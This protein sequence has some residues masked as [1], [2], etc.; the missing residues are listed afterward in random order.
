MIFIIIGVI[1]VW[2]WLIV[3]IEGL[4][5]ERRCLKI[6][7]SAR[8]SSHSLVSVVIP[9]RNE[10]RKIAE[11]LQSIENQDYKNIQVI[12]VNDRS[13]DQTQQIMEQFAKKNSHWILR[14]VQDLPQGWLGKNN[15]LRVGAREA[16]GHYLLFTD[17]DVK[18]ESQAIR[19]AVELSET[20]NLDHLVLFPRLISNDLLMSAMQCIF[21]VFFL[22]I[23]KPSKIGRSANYYVGVGA[24][25]LV[26]TSFY[27]KIGGH[28]KLRLEIID[29]LMLG[30]V[31]VA[32]GGK[33]EALIGKNL[34]SVEWYSDWRE[35]IQ[36]FEKNGFAAFRYSLFSFFLRT[37]LTFFFNL[38]PYVSL[39][40]ARGLGLY[41]ILLSLVMMFAI[42]SQ[43]AKKMDYSPMVLFLA[44]LGSWLIW[45]AQLRSVI[46]TL[47]NGGVSWRDTK[48][49]LSDLRK[50][51]I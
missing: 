49:N 4:R 48:Y 22:T 37:L 32:A 43:A 1:L 34:L 10:A 41:L 51:M 29:D 15:A 21:S 20:L 13:T 47:Y 30:K 35:M 39:F 7:N 11:C 33:Q 50:N 2:Q 3:A 44:P 14:T 9:A 46:I 19:T 18:F 17:G 26:R 42:F 28:Q 45:F 24:F 27:Q 23:F 31:I 25:N 16:Q 8:Q 12:M 40:F 5:F 36:G 38:V 6:E